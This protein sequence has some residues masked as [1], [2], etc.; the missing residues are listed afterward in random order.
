MNFWKFF[1][2]FFLVLG[3]AA[4]SANLTGKGKR[5]L[6]AEDV[7]NLPPLQ[8]PSDLTGFKSESYY[9]IPKKPDG[10]ENNFVS[11]NKLLVPP[12]SDLS[13]AKRKN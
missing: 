3:L 9:P 2:A 11:G 13:K 4:C 10:V 6:T 8:V 7:R 12:G 1:L 5:Q